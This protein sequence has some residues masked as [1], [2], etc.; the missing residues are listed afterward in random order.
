MATHD[1]LLLTEA[2]YE[3]PVD[4]DWYVQQ[5]LEDDALLAAALQKHGLKVRRIDWNT[6]D[7]DWSSARVAVFRTTWDYFYKIQEFT[8]WMEHA[9]SQVRFINP[10]SLIRWNLDKHYLLDLQERGIPIV[11]TVALEKG[12]VA[13]LNEY[14]AHFNT[15]E[16]VI[17]PCVAGAARETYRVKPDNAPEMTAHLNKLLEQEAMLV[18]PFFES[19]PRDGEVS[20][21]VINGAPQHAVLKRV[22]AGDFRVQDDFGGS[23]HPHTATEAEIQLALNAV[24]VCSPT[25]IY[26]RVDMIKNTAGQPVI[27]ELELI[28]P[29]LFLRKNPPAAEALAK[30]I[31]ESLNG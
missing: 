17:K 31:S 28:E 9:G 24:A 13:D 29:E 16:L 27:S 23:V 18:Q 14:F 20:V 19:V 25:P 7:F 3:H 10:L 30:G 11:P 2:R 8:A 12:H 1:V 15:S 5:I 21:V 4:P 6:P 22:K 26:A